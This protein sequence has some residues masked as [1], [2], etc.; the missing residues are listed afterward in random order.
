MPNHQYSLTLIQHQVQGSVIDQRASDGYIN[1][2]ALCKA[3]NKLWADY[4]RN[5]RTQRF[6]EVLAADMGIPISEIIQEVKGGEPTAQGTW[7]HPK[8]ATNLGMWCSPEFEVMV[9]SWVTDWI[10]SGHRP[11]QG[12]RQLPYHIERHMLNISSVPAGHFSILQ[13]MTF[14]LIGPLE[15]EGYELPESM[16]PDISM[17]RFLCKHLRDQLGI[18]T[19]SLPIYPHRYPDGRIVEAKLYPNEYLAEFR[20]IIQQQWLPNKAA[21]Y[22]K[23]RDPSALPYLDKVVLALPGP[24]TAANDPKIKFVRKKRN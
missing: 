21:E 4:K 2:S 9:T 24:R 7:V 20:R 14:M 13:E 1:A 8:V 11:S 17:G 18:D 22:F 15:Q 10:G 12:R 5:A 23:P 19:D 3:A 16:V 6:L